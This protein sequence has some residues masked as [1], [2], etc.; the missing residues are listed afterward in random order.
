[1]KSHFP[2]NDNLHIA[3]YWTLSSGIHAVRLKILSDASFQSCMEEGEVHCPIFTRLR[4]KDLGNLTFGEPEDIAETDISRLN[5]FLIGSKR[6]VDVQGSYDSVFRS[7]RTV[8]YL[9]FTTTDRRFKPSKWDLSW[10]RPLNK[11]TLP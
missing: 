4:L 10:D 11:I 5:K 3:K 7:F 1:M 9:V 2:Y 8:F 6:F